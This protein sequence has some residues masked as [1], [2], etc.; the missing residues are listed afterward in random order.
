MVAKLEKMLDVAK[1]RFEQNGSFTC[2]HM[3]PID[4]RISFHHP[5]GKSESFFHSSIFK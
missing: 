4:M 1:C 2:K 5:N 3:G